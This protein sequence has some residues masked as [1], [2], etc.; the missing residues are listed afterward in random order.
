M[1]ESGRRRGISIFGA[2]VGVVLSVVLAL[3][4]AV[5]VGLLAALPRAARADAGSRRGVRTRAGK[6]G[7]ERVTRKRASAHNAGAT[8]ELVARPGGP[9]RGQAVRFTLSV[10]VPDATGALVRSLAYGD[11]SSAPSVPVPQYCLAL[12]GRAA[13][14]TW[15]FSHSYAKAGSYHVTAAAGSNCGGGHATVRLTIRVR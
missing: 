4:I 10:R 6:S 12:P 13:S 15:H 2:G 7:G 3:A 5:V 1:N 8:I 14:E 11:G 9:E